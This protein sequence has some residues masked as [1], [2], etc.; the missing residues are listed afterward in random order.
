MIERSDLVLVSSAAE[1]GSLAAAARQLDLAPPAVSK[2]LAALESRLGLRLFHRST[3]R[4]QLTPHGEAFL[5]QARPLLQG[6][7]QLQAQ[8]TE[9]HDEPRGLIRL[10]SSFGFGHAWLGPLLAQF[11]AAYPQVQ[12]QLHL[13]EQLPDLRAAG[14]DAAVWLWAPRDPN[15]VTRRLASNRRIIVG[16]PAY[17]QR[18]GVPQTLDELAQHACLVVSENDDQP[19]TWRLQD[20]APRGAAV[21]MRVNGPLASNSGEVVRDWALAG[22]GLMLRSLWDVHEHLRS[23]RLQ[24]VLPRYAML[25]A[26]VHWVL[27]PRAPNS[28]VPRRV[29]LL[30]QQLIQALATPPWLAPPTQRPGQASAPPAPRRRR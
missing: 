27:P 23:G 24:Q 10:C 8:L 29:R 19:A 30:Q 18:A 15:V 3:R 28:S 2:R 14:F 25:D 9:R 26:D 5:A 7:E 16:A 4:L 17:L 1:L 11:H 22:H 20:L 12:V 13:R 21:T 6:F